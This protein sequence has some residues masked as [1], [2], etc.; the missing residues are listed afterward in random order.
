MKILYYHQWLKGHRLHIRT[1]INPERMCSTVIWWLM[2]GQFYKH[3][4]TI[5]KNI[6]QEIFNFTGNKA[7]YRLAELIVAPPAPKNCHKGDCPTISLSAQVR[8]SQSCRALWSQQSD[9]STWRS[10]RNRQQLWS[11]EKWTGDRK[12]YSAGK[13]I[14]KTVNRRWLP[15]TWKGT[16]TSFLSD[17]KKKKFKKN[18]WDE[19]KRKKK[20]QNNNKHMFSSSTV[21]ACR[22]VST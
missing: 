20:N 3:L 11:A 16:A 17:E 19:K 9:P 22:N 14:M 6:K 13:W 10:L 15:W 2:V 18:F 4:M 8:H 1:P 7:I 21:A 5:L 12:V